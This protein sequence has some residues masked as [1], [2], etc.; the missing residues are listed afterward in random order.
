MR[1]NLSAIQ[2]CSKVLQGKIKNRTMLRKVLA[3]MKMRQLV[4]NLPLLSMTLM[5]FLRAF[6][7]L[8]LLKITIKKTTP[9]IR[10]TAGKERKIVRTRRRKKKKPTRKRKTS[11]K[12]KTLHADFSDRIDADLVHLVKVVTSNTRKS[13]NASLSME[14]TTDLDVLD[15]INSTLKCAR[16]Q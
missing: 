3:L 9:R 6:P 13:A 10:K 12:R 15:V 2:N 11:L 7:V 1:N 14:R 8:K 16:L 5:N 4:R